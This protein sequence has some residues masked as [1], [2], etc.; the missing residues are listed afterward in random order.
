MRW[1]HPKL[2]SERTKREFLLLPLR[3][4][5]ETRWFETTEWVEMYVGPVRGWR[6]V[7]WKDKWE[8]I[9]T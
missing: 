9:K 6:I 5:D 1:T 4:G 7:E 2:W 3:I 8:T